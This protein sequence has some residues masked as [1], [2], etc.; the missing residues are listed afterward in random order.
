MILFKACPRCGGD[1]DATYPGE[2]FCVQCSHRPDAGFPQ[3]RITPQRPA[4]TGSP[5]AVTDPGPSAD[6]PRPRQAQVYAAM[7]DQAS[8]A[9][10]PR[11]SSGEL[12]RL[13]RLRHQDNTCYRCRTCGHI[14]SPAA[15]GAETQSQA[16]T[17]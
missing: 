17:P 16:T 4:V 2:V 13:D 12:I 11:C 10:C 15:G 14:F 8:A 7:T 3:P 1:L 6:G 5:P 9:P